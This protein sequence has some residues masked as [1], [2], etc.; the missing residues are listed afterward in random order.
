MHAA[1]PYEGRTAHEPPS[2]RAFTPGASQCHR[3]RHRRWDLPAGLVE[4]NR[5]TSAAGIP[6]DPYTY[7]VGA[8]SGGIYKT[9]D[10]GVHW[11]EI[12]DEQPVPSIGALAVAPGDPNVVWTGTG[13]AHIRSHICIGQG[14]YKSVDAGRHCTLMGLEMT[15]CIGRVVV[16]PT[17]PDI[18]MAGTLVRTLR[19]TN[20]AGLNRIHWDL[21]DEPSAEVRLQLRQVQR[22][23]ASDAEVSGRLRALDAR[24]IEAE[25]LLVDLRL[26]GAGQDQARFATTL[27]AK[28]EYLASGVATG[29]FRPTTQA[30]EVQGILGTELRNAQQAIEAALR[31]V[32]ALN[33]LL[34]GRGLPRVVDQRRIMP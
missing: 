30:A 32:P 1:A 5:F 4:G 33:Q 12:F 2:R 19:G 14:I 11:D 28:M 27:I 34:D 29:D 22:L 10:G 16:H 31:E 25:M 18:V 8:A 13:E 23:A 9:T 21:R 26:T 15:G 20:A 24:L 17:N 6:G 7:Y 3:C